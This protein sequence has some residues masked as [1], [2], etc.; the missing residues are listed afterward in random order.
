[1]QPETRHL[2]PSLARL[3]QFT[4][5]LRISV[6]SL[7]ILLSEIRASVPTNEIHMLCNFYSPLCV[8]L[9]TASSSQGSH[10]NGLPAITSDVTSLLTHYL[11]NQVDSF[12]FLQWKCTNVSFRQHFSHL[13]ILTFWHRG[14]TFNSNKSPT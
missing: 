6:K 13:H 14:L 10:A 1:V 8:R 12:S 11:V 9:V 2:F 4:H 3:V 7:T 5:S